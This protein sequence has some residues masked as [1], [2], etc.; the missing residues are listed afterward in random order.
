MGRSSNLA[1]HAVQGPT[2]IWC[3]HLPHPPRSGPTGAMTDAVL[4]MAIRGTRRVDVAAARETHEL[5]P[6][7]RSTRKSVLER[8]I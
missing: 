5:P 4:T 1:G 7:A 8:L 6:V 3:P 2:A